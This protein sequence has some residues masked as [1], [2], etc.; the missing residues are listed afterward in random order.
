MPMWDKKFYVYMMSN[1]WDTALYTGF[2]NSLF[3]RVRQHKEGKGGVF[4]AK[5]KCVKL[6]YYEEFDY[7]ND[8][9]ARE[10]QIKG[11]SRDRKESLVETLNPGWKDLSEGWDATKTFHSAC[12][13]RSRGERTE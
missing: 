7:V 2:S 1:K 10:N 9:L 11:W 3:D 5:Y 13:E 8:A 6:V 4:T 12:P